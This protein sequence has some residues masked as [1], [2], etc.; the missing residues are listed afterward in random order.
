MHLDEAKIIVKLAGPVM[1]ARAGAIILVT[2][3][4]IMV[5]AMGS[6][7]LAYYGIANALHL[8]PLLFGIGFLVAV[9]V[10][11][12]NYDGAGK[13]E[14]CGAV[15]KIGVIHA[16]VVGLVITLLLQFG[17]ELLRLTGQSEQLS[18]EGG[19][20]LVMHSVGIVP[21]LAMI[22]TSMFLEG[23]HRPVPGMVAMLFAN[24]LNVLF[25]WMLIYGN[26]GLPAMGAEGAALATSVVRWLGFI[27]LA[28]YTL[29]C[30]DNEKYG[31]RTK[32]ANG[33]EMSKR[34]RTLGYPTGIAHGVESTSFAIMTMFAG[35]MGILEAAVWTIGMNLITIPFMCSLGFCTAA[36]VRVAYKLGQG[37]VK[38]AE[39]SGWL[40]TA[41]A[42][43][44]LIAIGVA[45]FGVPELLSKIYNREPQVLLFAVP[46]VAFAA[47]V[48]I[49]DGLQVVL[50]G[51]LR[52]LQDMWYIAL[53]LLVGFVVVMLPMAYYLGVMRHGT[54]IDLMVAVTVGA[55]VVL[56]MLAV[57]F[58]HLCRNLQIKHGAPA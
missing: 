1:L 40:A 57:R 30:V 21:M 46:T 23:L 54:P 39:E 6:G 8:A 12:A 58:R 2:V 28:L 53:A 55:T 56:V 4:A 38:D 3:D 9:V 13:S 41:L 27:G 25:N 19:Q 11:T 10:L 31:I 43:I 18:I 22:A 7:E 42:L 26:L 24:L 33:F 35:L 51:A 49:P 52:G 44:L 15:W 14:M 36:S 32:L 16:V 29:A 37:N 50:V 20:V 45:Y 48:L 47:L 17:E 5:G 34:M